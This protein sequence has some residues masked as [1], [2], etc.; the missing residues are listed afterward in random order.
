MEGI[1]H[2]EP[3]ELATIP[4]FAGLGEDKLAAI[5]THFEVME[6]PKGKSP[7]E[8]GQHGYSFFVLA[9][10]AARVEADGEVVEHLQ[11]GSMFGEMA[12][13]APD[14]RRSATVIPESDLRVFWLFGTDFLEM[15][16]DYPEIAQRVR[17]SYDERHARDVARS[18]E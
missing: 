13:F 10:G 9:D 8:S 18:A 7:A 12:F 1:V 17:A 11:P 16:R 14:S 6:I 5:A 2:P 15:E 3:S 4:L